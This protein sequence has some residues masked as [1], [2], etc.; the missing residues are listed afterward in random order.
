MFITGSRVYGTPTK[1]SDI[2]IV[3]Y[4]PDYK[5]RDLLTDLSDNCGMPCR[6][7]NLN[8]IYAF[9]LKEYAV[10][11]MCRTACLNKVKELDRKLTKEEALEIH[12]RVRKENGLE[13]REGDSG[14]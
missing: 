11:L 13:Y 9:T 5:E 1:D 10:W 7:G 3:V 8:I 4:A 12:E 6:F 14:Q 2:D